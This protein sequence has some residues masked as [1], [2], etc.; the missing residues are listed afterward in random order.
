MNR[1]TKILLINMMTAI[2]IS[3]GYNDDTKNGL[4]SDTS[5][6][7]LNYWYQKIIPPKNATTNK[8]I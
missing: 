5:H 8:E 1:I 4:H 3:Y 6:Y 7:S 2:L